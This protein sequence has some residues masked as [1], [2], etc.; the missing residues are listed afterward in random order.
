VAQARA[1]ITDT[2]PEPEGEPEPDGAP[3]SAPVVWTLSTRQ[4][5]TAFVLVLVLLATSQLVW[6]GSLS[7]RDRVAPPAT[8][9]GMTAGGVPPAVLS[10]PSTPEARA[11]VHEFVLAYEA[12]DAGRIADLFAPDATDDDRRGS[13]AIRAEYERTFA[14]LADV[15]WAVPRIET[16]PRGDRVAIAGPVVI[17]FLDRTGTRGARRGT[18]EWEIVR[19]DGTP[20]ITRLQ[21][22]VADDPSG[23]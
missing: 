17:T 19:R 4:L 6:R 23:G 9:F 11:L 21:T 12:R 14:R 13:T 10:A 8:I 7:E 1:T 16:T 15:V 18:A 2:V 3:P 22:D 20:R 5:A